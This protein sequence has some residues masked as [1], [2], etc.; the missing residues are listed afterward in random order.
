MWPGAPP[1]PGSFRDNVPPQATTLVDAI[2]KGQRMFG[3]ARRLWHDEAGVVISAELVLILTIVVLGVI[4]G[5]V[6][7]RNAVV[8][9]LNDLSLAFSH[10]NQSYGYTGF[11]GGWK[12]WCGWTS[13]TAGS[14]FIDVYDGAGVASLADIGVGRFGYGGFAFGSG[15][16]GYCC[17]GTIVLMD[18]TLIPIHAVSPGTWVLPGGAVFAEFAD[19]RGYLLLADGTSIPFLVGICG[20]VELADGKVIAARPG[21]AGTVVLPDGQVATFSAAEAERVVL[22]DGTTLRFR[23]PPADHVILADGTMVAAKTGEAGTLVLA[24]GRVLQLRDAVLPP[25]T[26]AYHA[27]PARPVF[28]H[29]PA[30][31]GG[32]PCCDGMIPGAPVVPHHEA[33]P[34]APCPPPCVA[35]ESKKCD[36]CAPRRVCPKPEIPAGP[37][38]QYLPQV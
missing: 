25:G 23:L 24:D 35:P 29:G 14:S 28:P 15:F 3:T 6:E 36:D 13:W 2:Q 8:A 22:S 38:P 20:T 12:P 5:L 32:P 30:I 26:E 10:L 18:G 1:F 9:E 33:P 37:I 34:A 17:S 19:R 4:V 31:P 16:S 11:I 7:V 21:A 27:P